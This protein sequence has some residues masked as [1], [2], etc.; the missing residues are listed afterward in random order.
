MNSEIMITQVK[1]KIQ[2]AGLFFR[3]MTLTNFICYF[4]LVGPPLPKGEDF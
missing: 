4:S 2:E 1:E 3:S